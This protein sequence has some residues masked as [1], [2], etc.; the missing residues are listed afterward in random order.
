MLTVVAA[1]AHP[2]IDQQI[3]DVTAAIEAAPADASLR[4]KRGEL[5][6]IHRDWDLARRDFDAAAKLAPEDPIVEFHRARLELDVD[7][8][9]AALKRIGRY[10]SLAPA[11]GP[12]APVVHARTL[13]A[14]GRHRAAADAYTRAIEGS[15]EGRPS[16]D[17]YLERARALRAA[18]KKHR[19]EAL[20]GL[21]EGI[22]RLGGPI[23]LRR[24]EIEIEIESGRVDDA[25]ARLGRIAD[26]AGRKER[27][28][29]ERGDILAAASRNREALDAYSAAIEAIEALP[30]SRRNNNATVRLETRVRDSIA[31]LS[32][33]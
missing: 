21:D 27:W 7:Q 33:R 20:R 13:V 8:P 6:R 9:K 28:H 17:D 26:G 15:R 25:L 23:T 2:G 4:I 10:L 32:R 5:H 24:L 19:D 14:L 30:A 31:K 16:P 22:E 18:G 1:Q 3:A 29:A 11:A 12:R